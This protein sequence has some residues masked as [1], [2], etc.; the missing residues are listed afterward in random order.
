MQPKQTRFVLDDQQYTAEQT[1]HGNLIMHGGYPNHVL[2]LVR[3]N[4]KNK[5]EINAAAVLL[6]KFSLDSAVS[7][8]LKISSVFRQYN[9]TKVC[10][11]LGRLS[12]TKNKNQ[13][14]TGRVRSR[15]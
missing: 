5:H 6:M 11:T 12:Q 9:N 4:Q 14:K 15:D 2:C 7:A 8:T 3:R 13:S 10:A 1:Q